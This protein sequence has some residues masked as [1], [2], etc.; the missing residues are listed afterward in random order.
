VLGGVGFYRVSEY[1]EVVFCGGF[2]GLLD[3]VLEQ[4]QYVIPRMD[5]TIIN[6]TSEK[7]LFFISFL[8]ADFADFRRLAVVKD[9]P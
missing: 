6:S 5:T 8:S 9:L 2:L 4:G 1:S 7:A 3:V